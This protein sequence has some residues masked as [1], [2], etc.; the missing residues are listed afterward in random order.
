MTKEEFTVRLEANLKSAVKIKGSTFI[1]N[2]Y[3][4]DEFFFMEIEE[5]LE[6]GEFNPVEWLLDDGEFLWKF[7]G[8]CE[9]YPFVSFDGK[10][11]GLIFR[12]CNLDV[13]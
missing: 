1:S 10:T 8:E 6:I 11:R 13:L 7:E 9:S 3:D 5:G 12:D 2:S 4:P